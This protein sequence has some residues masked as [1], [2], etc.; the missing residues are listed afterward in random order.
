MGD[1]GRFS[2]AGDAAGAAANDEKIELEGVVAWGGGNEEKRKREMR[3]RR[4]N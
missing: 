1:L 3:S 4:R 2:G